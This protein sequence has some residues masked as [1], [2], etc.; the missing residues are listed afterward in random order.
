VPL[1][2]N[3]DSWELPVVGFAVTDIWFSG[4]VYVTA[5]GRGD[6]TKGIA[7]PTARITLGGAFV[8]RS[9]DGAEHRLSA[10]D[11]WITLTPLFSLRHS[12]IDRAIA[13]RTGSLRVEFEDAASLWVGPHPRYE[14]WEFTGPDGLYLVAPP[15]GGDPRI[16]N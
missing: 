11:A 3:A 1:D 5:Y 6:A 15:G 9:A 7:T 14:N 16:S 10:E 2:P 4:Q 13:D 12:S 8:L